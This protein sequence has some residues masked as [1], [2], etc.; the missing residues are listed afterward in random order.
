[1][2][3]VKGL[4]SLAVIVAATFGGLRIAH[5]SAPIVFPETR[6]GPV[7]IASLDELKRRAGFS[8]LFP[9]Y[10][11][12]ELGDR[13]A[14]ITLLFNPRPTCA[15]VWASGDQYLSVTQ[16]M[17]GSPPAV[18]PLAQPFEDVAG[19]SWWT[20]DNRSHLVLSRGEFFI[21][22]E[23]SRSLRDLRRF[24]DTLTAY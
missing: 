22:I 4:T 24:A 15:I 13:P 16:R 17:G 2:A 21:T 6:R 11:P 5:V 3:G 12:A 14:S 7:T 23:T 18:P 9:A 19:S 8:P 20:S 1:M 10:R